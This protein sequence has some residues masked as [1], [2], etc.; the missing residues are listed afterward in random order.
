MFIYIHTECTT[1]IQY[2]CVYWREVGVV[3]SMNSLKVP[4]H[5]SLLWNSDGGLADQ[6]NS[7]RMTF[8]KKK[9]KSSSH[10]VWKC[11]FW[12]L[13]WYSSPT[14]FYTVSLGD[15]VAN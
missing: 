3:V 13:T 11:C 10:S 8:W 7:L 1:Y 12:F 6:T 14:N 9:K 4:L 15:I 5:I 2:M